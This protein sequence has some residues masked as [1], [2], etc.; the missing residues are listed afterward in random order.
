MRAGVEP[1]MRFHQV[2]MPNEGGGG[3]RRKEQEREREEVLST[4]GSQ[5]RLVAREM[6]GGIEREW[7]HWI[8]GSGE[9]RSRGGV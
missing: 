4:V 9:L 1:E 5:N 3:G 2:M 6:R 7:V 8:Q